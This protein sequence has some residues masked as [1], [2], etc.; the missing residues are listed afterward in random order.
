MDRAT[1]EEFATEFSSQLLPA[2]GARGAGGGS[3][4]LRSA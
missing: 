3:C 1:A 4:V 2:L